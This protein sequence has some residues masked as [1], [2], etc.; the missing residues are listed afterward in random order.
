MKFEHYTIKVDVKCK[1]KIQNANYK[2]KLNQIH[3]C[4]E[5]NATITNYP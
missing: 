3:V 1:V 2:D 4:K 5:Y